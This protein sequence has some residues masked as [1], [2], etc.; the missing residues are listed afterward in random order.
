MQCRLDSLQDT[1][2]LGHVLAAM[3]Y[4]LGPCPILISGTL[5][6]GKTTLIRHIVAH[7][8][9]GDQAEVSSPSFNLVNIYPTQ[10]EVVHMDL[11]RLGDLGMDESLAEYLDAL[12]SALLVEWAD[13]LPDTEVPEHYLWVHIHPDTQGREVR[14]SA[15]E[16]PGQDW[17]GYVRKAFGM[18]G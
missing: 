4:T 15:P 17:L 5:G 9:N 8:E 1:D 14:L 13:Y 18:T 7:L 11:Y 12:N 2:H 16:G 3:L 10:P 6:A